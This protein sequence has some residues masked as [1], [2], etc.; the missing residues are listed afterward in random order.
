MK[1]MGYRL[2]LV[3]E[4]DPSCDGFLKDSEYRLM[5]DHL[6]ESGT[7]IVFSWRDLD[8][9][10]VPIGVIGDKNK[11]KLLRNFSL[12]EL[13]DVIF[14]GQLGKIHN[15]PEKFLF[16]LSCLDKFNGGVI[17]DLN[18]IRNNLSKDYLLDLQDKGFRV[19]PTKEVNVPVSVEELKRISFGMGEEDLI[20]KPKVF[21]EKGNGVRKLSSFRDE[22]DFLQYS[23][24]HAPLLVQPY[25]SSIVS[26]GENSLVYVGGKFSHALRKATGELL[27]NTNLDT[28]ICEKYTPSEEEMQI[29]ERVISLYNNL[30]GYCRLDFI[31]WNGKSYLSEVE[32]VNPGCSIERL[33]ITEE[34]TEKVKVLIKVNLEKVEK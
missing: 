4:I 31:P 5:F 16:F 19:V 21:G 11:V 29:S 26:D 7:V 28:R 25:I 8:G 18:L 32:M 27:V 6:R 14:I 34:F 13:C 15:S 3:A 23:K 30:K 17:N 24:E 20:L 10:N 12:N 22:E 1:K 33:G 2:G 9:L